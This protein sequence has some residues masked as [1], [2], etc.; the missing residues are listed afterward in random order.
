MFAADNIFEFLHS[1][2]GSSN[3]SSLGDSIGA[4]RSDMRM[5]VAVPLDDGASSHGRA[6][7]RRYRRGAAPYGDAPACSGVSF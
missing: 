7:V 1:G 5:L 2:G 4:T 3:S 6:G